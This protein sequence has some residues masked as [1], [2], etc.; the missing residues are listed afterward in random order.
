MR[1]SKP[2][3]EK[4]KEIKQRLKKSMVLIQHT[5]VRQVLLQHSFYKSFITF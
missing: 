5:K 2:D 1:K 4:D 3:K